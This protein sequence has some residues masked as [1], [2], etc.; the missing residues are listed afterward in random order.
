MEV[1][2]VLVH[3]MMAY[4]GMGG[5]NPFILN[6]DTG[7]SEWSAP[8]PIRFTPEGSTLGTHSV[9][10]WMSPRTDLDALEKKAISYPFGN[11]TTI[12]IILSQLP[13]CPR[14]LF[15]VKTVLCCCKVNLS[16]VI[17]LDSHELFCFYFVKQ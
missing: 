15:N 6:L 16:L 13:Y 2:F 3:A 4:A 1:K 8:R 7:W 12:P 14:W 10:G 17:G 5:I 11:R 9:A